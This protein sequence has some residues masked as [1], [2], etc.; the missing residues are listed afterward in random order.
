MNIKEFL[1]LL[2]PLKGI[3]QKNQKIQF[4]FGPA[5]RSRQTADGKRSMLARFS[6]TTSVSEPVLCRDTDRAT[7]TAADG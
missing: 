4:R 1:S 5:S 2:N 7:D 3:I 6:M